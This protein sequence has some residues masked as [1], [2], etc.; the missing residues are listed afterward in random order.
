MLELS[1]ASKA[2]KAASTLPRGSVSINAG[3]NMVC[4]PDEASSTFPPRLRITLLL[5][6]AICMASASVRLSDS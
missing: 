1:W 3:L 2:L 6:S 5:L 4:E